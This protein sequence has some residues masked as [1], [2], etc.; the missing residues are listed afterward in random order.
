M[1]TKCQNSTFVYITPRT[2]PVTHLTPTHLKHNAEV[3]GPFLPSHPIPNPKP[4]NTTNI[5]QVLHSCV[6]LSPKQTNSPA[7]SSTSSVKGYFARSR[8]ILWAWGMRLE[9]FCECPIF[10]YPCFSFVRSFHFSFAYFPCVVIHITNVN[11]HPARNPNPHPKNKPKPQS[12]SAIR[13]YTPSWASW[14]LA[15]PANPNGA[16]YSSPTKRTP[17][18]RD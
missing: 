11:P 1:Q 5:Y 9:R 10:F 13:L 2:T 12:E 3:N 17:A 18:N 16:A 8:R 7:S 14:L 4:A 15:L 6:H